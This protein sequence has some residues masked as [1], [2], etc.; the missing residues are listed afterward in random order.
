MVHDPSE[1]HWYRYGAVPPD[2]LAVKLID[3]PESIMGF[4]GVADPAT[5]TGLTVSWSDEDKALTAGLPAELS[6]TE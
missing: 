5:R 4:V 1:Y 2:G 3:W 6:V